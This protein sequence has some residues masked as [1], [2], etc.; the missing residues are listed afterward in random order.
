MTSVHPPFDVRIFHKQCR[1]L[2]QAGYDVTLIVPHDKDEC[3]DGV[4]IVA[5]SKSGNRKERF[6]KTG[7]AVYRAALAVKA[8]IYHIHDPELLPYAQL[9]RLRGKKVIYDMHENLP[10]AILT[11]DWISPGK[12]RLLAWLVHTAERFLLAGLAVVFA[13]TSYKKDYRWVN[14]GTDVLNMPDID[15][16][17]KLNHTKKGDAFSIG[18]VGGVTPTRGSITMLEAVALLQSEGIDCSFHCI[19]PAEPQHNAELISLIERLSLKKTYLYGYMPPQQAWD[20]ISKCQVGMAVL[21]PIPNYY[22][23]Y[24]TKMFEYMALGIPVITS[25]FPLYQEVIEGYNCGLCVDPESPQAIANAVSYLCNHPQDAKKM[26]ENGRIAVT[27]EY[28]WQREEGH[29]L[30]LYD[31]LLT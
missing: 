26:G 7:R 20:I 23:S 18:Y 19:G 1:S 17:L 8:D 29:L 13:E 11:K 25:N 4:K 31:Q 21:K 28:N 5:V 24:P 14:N 9:L 3:I 2:V 10:R 22:E 27:K 16:L 6:L 15:Y 12:R 30:K